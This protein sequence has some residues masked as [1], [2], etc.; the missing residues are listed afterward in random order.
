MIEAVIF[1]FDGTIIDTETIWYQAY[2]DVLRK[3][4]GI[5]LPLEVFAKVIGT[6][7]EVL[8]KFIEDQASTT[9]N[10][11][12]IESLVHECFLEKKSE[13]EL[14]P[15]VRERLQEAKDL[16]LKLGIASSSSRAWVE[17]YLN[18]FDLWSYFSVVKTKEDVVRVKPDPSLYRKALQ[19]L[20]VEPERALAIEDSVNGS[21]AAIEAG[22]KCWVVP[23]PVTSFLRFHEKVTRFDSFL[24][25][26]FQM[27]H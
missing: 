1:D 25:F 14:R 8:F 20:Q 13:L 7:D 18:Q 5:E 22:M 16:D 12:E 26:D 4:Y 24:D 17:G 21:I 19:S 6:T 2:K 9:I 3:Q 15:G 10:K 11:Q 23:N 27:F